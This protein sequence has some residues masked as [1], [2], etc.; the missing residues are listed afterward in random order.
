MYNTYDKT[1]WNIITFISS[2][3][4][5]EIP[6]EEKTS[7][8]VSNFIRRSGRERK[9]FPCAV[10]DCSVVERDID[11]IL[12]HIKVNHPS[13]Y[14]ALITVKHSKVFK[15]CE[16][17]SFIFLCKESYESH[18]DLSLCN[19]NKKFRLKFLKEDKFEELDMK[20][21]TENYEWK[22]SQID[23]RRNKSKRR[24]QTPSKNS[25]G[26]ITPP[27]STR[28]VTPSKTTT[29]GADSK[30]SGKLKFA[31]SFGCQKF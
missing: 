24:P 2:K 6:V 9:Q 15:V 10:K 27:R 12:R 14:A 25:T 7:P 29:R 16:K 8:D 23:L 21:L 28:P 13:H 18:L 11:K 30:I 26:K 20:I 31:E 19:G 22:Y 17:C 3:I 5:P 1:I 4:E